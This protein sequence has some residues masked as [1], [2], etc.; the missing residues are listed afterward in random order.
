MCE[1]SAAQRLIEVFGEVTPTWRRLIDLDPEFA[2]AFSS[3]IHAAVVRAQFTP[4]ERELLLLAHDVSI[5][6]LD[7]PGVKRRIRR[8]LDAGATEDEVL[9]VV[10][11]TAFIAIHGVTLGLPLATTLPEG[12]PTDQLGA[13]W[14]EFEKTFPG[15]NKGI[16]D[17]LPDFY[18]AYR[19]FG[20]VM[21]AKK[22]IEPRL[23]ELLLV[24]ADMTNQHLFTSGASLHIKQA[25]HDGATEAEVIAAIALTAADAHRSIELGVSAFDEVTR[26][27]R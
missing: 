17:H 16:E 3:Y 18:E 13:Y 14:D 4:R 12:R 11:F 6:V 5:T 27:N 23:R 15:L 21:W 7:E 20:A 22:A 2:D 1:V 25:L 26:K 8:A 10:E 9:T 19:S 24:V